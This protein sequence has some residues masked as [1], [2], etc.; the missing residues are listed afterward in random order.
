[1]IWCRYISKI[2]ICVHPT[3]VLHN[4]VDF[5]ILAKKYIISMSV[6]VR[7]QLRLFEIDITNVTSKIMSEMHCSIRTNATSGDQ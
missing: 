7:S 6:H 3:K 5:L 1:M 4:K 2:L